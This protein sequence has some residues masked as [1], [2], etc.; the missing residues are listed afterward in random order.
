[1]CVYVCV[2]VQLLLCHSLHT[3]THTPQTNKTKKIAQ[4]HTHTH[5]SHT[6]VH[7]QSRIRTH[8]HNTHINKSFTYITH[9]TK[10]KGMPTRNTYKTERGVAFKTFINTANR[11]D[12]FY[13]YSGPVL[14][15]NPQFASHFNGYIVCV[16]CVCVCVYVCVCDKHALLSIDNMHYS[17]F[18]TMFPY[19]AH[20][21]THTHTHICKKVSVL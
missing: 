16:V 15:L 20:T 2:C 19:N 8:T 17:E 7:T 21:H 1:M 13:Y 4:S 6:H 9:N 11:T 5:T 14:D 18:N 12:V 10:I 3:H